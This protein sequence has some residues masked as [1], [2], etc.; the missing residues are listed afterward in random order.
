MNTTLFA[1]IQR[2]EKLL[3]DPRL[4]VDAQLTWSQHLK[5]LNEKRI[6]HARERNA[7]SKKFFARMSGVNVDG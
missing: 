7:E 4:P 1:R 6:E 2:I 3:E 5:S